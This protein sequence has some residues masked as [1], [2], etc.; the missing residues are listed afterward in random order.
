MKTLLNSVSRD[1]VSLNE[2]SKQYIK[3]FNEITNSINDNTRNVVISNQL[4]NFT[5][6][7]NEQRKDINLLVDEV[8]G[9]KHGIIHPQ[10]LPPKIF[11][12]ELQI[13]EKRHNNKYPIQ[14]NKKSYQHLIDISEIGI[15]NVN[16]RLLYSIK[17]SFIESDN[18]FTFRLIPIPKKIGNVFLAV[19]P[20]HKFSMVNKQKTLYV[21]T[22]RET[23]NSC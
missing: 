8:N 18:Y 3:N 10:I 11:M 1:I 5:S 15:A 16:K 17:I 9:G 4:T 13:F 20:E 7:I 14:V 22:N 12:E 23:I 19:I 2:R 6:I 21:P